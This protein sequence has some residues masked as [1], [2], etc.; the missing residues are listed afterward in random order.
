MA[1][2]TN[3]GFGHERRR[4]TRVPLEGTV[5]VDSVS[6]G[7]G[8]GRCINVGRG[9]VT[10]ALRQYHRP[11]RQVTLTLP[12]HGGKSVTVPATVVW[13]RGRAGGADFVTGL[14]VPE[15]P[16]VSRAM[17]RVLL[18]ALLTAP[19]DP[20]TAQPAGLMHTPAVV[21]PHGWC[22]PQAPAHA[23][24]WHEAVTGQAV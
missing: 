5:R 20:A 16:D 11:G 23:G 24:G 13:S 3:H 7:N 6:L 10:V 1:A 18:A 12:V 14:H 21:A 17:S 9:G 8:L 4:F 2:T 22:S 19:R 15:N